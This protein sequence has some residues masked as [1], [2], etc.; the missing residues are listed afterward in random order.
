M[1]RGRGTSDAIVAVLAR[2]H[3]KAKPPAEP[4]LPEV[5]NYVTTQLS[6][7]VTTQL[8]DYMTTDYHTFFVSNEFN[9][10]M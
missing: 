8:S 5:F 6:D 3:V 10:F 1:R 4:S 2:R 9:T 7:Y